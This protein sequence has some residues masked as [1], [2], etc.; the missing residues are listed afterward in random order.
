MLRGRISIFSKE[1]PRLVIRI[2]FVSFGRKFYGTEVH[3][4]MLVM[5]D[6]AQVFCEAI[7]KGIR[8]G[9]GVVRA[10]LLVRSNRVFHLL[11]QVGIDI[12]FL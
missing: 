1:Q 5:A 4:Q 7:G 12:G 11:R 6:R 10:L 3:T 8:I 9:D 2:R